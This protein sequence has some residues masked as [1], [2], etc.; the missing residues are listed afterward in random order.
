VVI[1]P[2]SA[3][4]LGPGVG[5]S[6]VPTVLIGLLASLLVALLLLT[7][8]TAWRRAA[9]RLLAGGLLRDGGR[10][11]TI[12]A[13]VAVDDPTIAPLAAPGPPTASWAD[14]NADADAAIAAPSPADPFRATP[15]AA[16]P[17]PTSAWT[18]WLRAHAIEAALLGGMLVAT[19]LRAPRRTRSR[20]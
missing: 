17:A 5:G 4:L 11:G 18:R 1:T 15:T 8:P 12:A 16:E 19:V 6:S 14:A 3:R 10:A 9:P 13:A 7:V 2:A 20:R